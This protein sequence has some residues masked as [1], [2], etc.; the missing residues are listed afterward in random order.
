MNNR[1]LILH[2]RTTRTSR[3]ACK[4]I[5]PEGEPLC[6]FLV[7]GNKVRENAKELKSV[8]LRT[9]SAKASPPPDTLLKGE[10]LTANHRR[11]LQQRVRQGAVEEAISCTAQTVRP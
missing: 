6:L 11:Q 2:Q 7:K 10:Q 1:S 9:P 3:K 8:M 5:S 4:S